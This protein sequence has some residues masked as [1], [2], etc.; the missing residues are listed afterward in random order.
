MSGGNNPTPSPSSPPSSS[1]VAE[2]FSGLPA[3]SLD[4][5]KSDADS[6]QAKALSWLQKDPKFNEYKHV[7]RLY[8][9]Y[10]LAVLYYSTNGRRRGRQTGGGYRMTMNVV[11]TWMTKFT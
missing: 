9:R 10:A 11:G 7:Y 4:L 1:V 5:A 2:F 3:Y 8:Q 6:P